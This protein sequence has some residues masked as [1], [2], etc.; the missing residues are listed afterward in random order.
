MNNSQNNAHA[1][2]E[3]TELTADTVND[4]DT[5]VE[6]ITNMTELIAMA[7]KEQSSFIQ[8]VGEKVTSI[9]DAAHENTQNAEESVKASEQ[10]N[11]LALSLKTIS[12]KFKIAN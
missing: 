6:S 2:I 11:S 9:S 5:N 3:K 7:A 10:I 4:V 12:S 8:E 1:T